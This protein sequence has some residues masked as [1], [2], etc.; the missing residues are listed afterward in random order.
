MIGEII[1]GYCSGSIA[2]LADAAHMSS[3]VFGFMISYY[4]IKWT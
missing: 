2:I 4:A 3:D 1:G